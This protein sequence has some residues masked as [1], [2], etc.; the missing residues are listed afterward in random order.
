MKCLIIANDV[1]NSAPGIVNETI[2][3]EMCKHV[4]VS[5]FSIQGRDDLDLDVQMLPTASSGK[6]LMRIEKMM[7]SLFGRN[8]L[9][10][11]WLFRQKKLIKGKRIEKYD[12]ILSLISHHNYKSLLL[13][14]YLS[15]KLRKKWIIYSVD[16]IPAPL[17]WEKDSLSYH[18]TRK[19]INKYISRCDAFFSANQQMLEYQLSSLKRTD[20]VSG[21]L[22]TPIRTD[23]TDYNSVDMMKNENSIF[24]YTGGIYGPRKIDSLLEGFRLYLKEAPASRLIFVGTNFCR[25][26][27]DYKDLIDSGNIEIHGFT[28]DLLPFYNMASALI[29]VNAYFENDVFL[30]SKIINY[31]P[32]RKPIISITGF[33]SPSRNIFVSDSS[34]I[35]CQHQANEIYEAFKASS[36]MQTI[37]WTD[38]NKYIKLFSVDNVVNSFM[39]QIRTR[40]GFS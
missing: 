34:I 15:R 4:D 36:K 16:A 25:Y 29:D 9:D 2:I 30:S 40:V 20:I 6:H 12:A 1:G 3:R 26:N 27:S 11:Y 38:R 13:G 10:D 7:F 23:Y 32:I 14:D 31:L 28:H 19:F 18:N 37:D 5:L 22:F 35:H 24:L 21:V 33:N 39:E 17:G 8:L